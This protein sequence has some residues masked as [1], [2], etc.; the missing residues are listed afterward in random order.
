M[1]LS[2]ICSTPAIVCRRPQL[3][4]IILLELPAVP[5]SLTTA[6]DAIETRADSIHI[7]L[8]ELAFRL[9]NSRCHPFGL[10]AIASYLQR[11]VL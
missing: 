1:L 11:L 10:L 8:L 7:T 3:V 4:F 6:I 9:L 5:D 2:L